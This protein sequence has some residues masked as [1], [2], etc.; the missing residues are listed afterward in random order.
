M[1]L[2]DRSV[3]AD[4]DDRGGAA[5]GESEGDMSRALVL[6]M[7][8]AADEDM[9]LR[10]RRPHTSTNYQLRMSETKLEMSLVDWPI[11]AYW[12]LMCC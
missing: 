9:V 6:R 4:C 8:V 2:F 10:D 5:R 7:C 11:L 3:R 1:S 12:A